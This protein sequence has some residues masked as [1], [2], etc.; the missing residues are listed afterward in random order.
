LRALR[1][2]S[3][4]LEIF[5]HTRVPDGHVL[6]PD[7]F[8]TRPAEES[9][10]A[11]IEGVRPDLLLF[12]T[13]FPKD[14]PPPGANRDRAR[15]SVVHTLRYVRPEKLDAIFQSPWMR[16]VR[17][18][19]VPHEPGEVELEIPKGP[20]TVF[21]G[22]I[23][24]ERS[25]G[26]AASLRARFGIEP[27][28][29]LVVASL[30]GGGVPE[31][32]RRFVE[33]VLEGFRRA[34]ARH[35]GL[36]L[37]LVTGPKNAG[38][39]D[40]PVEDPAVRAVAFEPDLPALY[41]SARL[42]I[43]HGGYNTTNEILSARTPALFLPCPAKYDDGV[44]RAERLVERGVAFLGEAGDGGRVAEVLEEYFAS[45]EVEAR[46]RARLA[47]AS[48][49]AGND[50]AARA[51]ASLLA[52]HRDEV[53][54]ADVPLAATATSEPGPTEQ[55]P[56]RLPV[57][58][59]HLVHPAISDAY[60]VTPEI[61]EAQ[62]DWLAEHA[63]V[64]GPR[65]ALEAFESG[66]P[67]PPG[68]V[69]LAFDDG[70]ESFLEHALPALRGR[71]MTA[72]LFLVTSY[73]GKANEWNSRAKYL[74]RHLSW[75]QARDLLREGFETAAHGRTHQALVKFDRDRIKSELHGAAN[76]IR[77]AIGHD[78]R[79][80][81]YPYGSHDDVVTKVARKR[82]RLGFASGPKGVKDWREDSMRIHRIVVGPTTSLAELAARLHRY[83]RG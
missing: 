81:A 14:P 19:L 33:S 29:A 78:T 24:A 37:V 69:L 57:L 75:E 4:E 56:F 23:L 13:L 47:Q 64:I 76:D 15:P 70:Y 54:L 31:F 18:L 20:R 35:R 60:S 40:V 83:V 50:R 80:V 82:F 17:L 9:L 44:E 6:R 43:A 51:I 39:L 53:A 49:E 65:E 12:D 72:A 7:E 25:A 26:D 71:G 79:L 68:A 46:M 77:E 58:S 61:L 41:A 34:R 1:R 36:K 45:P 2:A 48:L 32:A 3:S 66:A 11:A 10:V 59:Y 30:G 62:L 63:R 21:V 5:L 28:D 8:E 52:E 42:V 73:M 27:E 74:A 16:W 38:A 55:V 22:P 67:A